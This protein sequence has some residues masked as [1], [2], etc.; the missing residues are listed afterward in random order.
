MS[1]P[2]T[3]ETPAQLREYA[4][5]QK[6]AAE[7]ATAELETLRAENRTNALLA[8][9]VNPDS[10]V[11]AMFSKAYD[12]D[13]KVDAIK[14]E[15][16]KVAPAPTAAAAAPPDDGPSEAEKAQAAQRSQLTTGGQ[17]PGEE[18]TPHPNVA[19]KAAF[20]KARG[21][22][23][24]VETAQRDYVQVIMNAAAAGDERVLA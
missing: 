23:K 14:E 18:P 7:A 6:V 22:G 9:G 2:T 5:R 13:L 8:A 11:G 12:G 15:W 19:A 4:D 10:P 21:E 24:S 20:D 3:N 16:L 1:D 17:P